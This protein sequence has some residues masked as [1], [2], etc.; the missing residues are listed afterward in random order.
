MPH[1]LLRAHEVME[2][3]FNVAGVE[4]PVSIRDQ[5]NRGH[6]LVQQAYDL[7]F[8][9]PTRERKYRRLLI[10]GAGAAGVSAALHAL[11][12]GVETV[13]VERTSAPFLLQ[14]LCA[15][16]WIDPAQY[17]WSA[18]WSAVDWSYGDF[19]YP[20]SP[21]MRLAWQANRSNRIAINWWQHWRAALA[22]PQLTFRPRDWVVGHP[23]PALRG[24]T[25]VGVEVSFQNGKPEQF[26]M[27]LWC[28][29]FGD[30]RRYAPP[31]YTGFAF[32]QTDTFERQ[33]WGIAKPPDDLCAIVS[34]GGDGALQDIIRLCTGRKSAKDVFQALEGVGW[35]LPQEIRQNLF[36]E[37]DQAQRALL[38]C[39]RRSLDEHRVLTRLHDAY[40][41]AV[42]HLA[43]VDPQ[44]DT[45]KVEVRRLLAWNPHP[46]VLVHPCCHF[47]RC[48]GLNR[49][50]VL[51]IA[52]VAALDK[53]GAGPTILRGVGVSRVVGTSALH[54]CGS[55]WVCHGVEHEVEIEHRPDCYASAGG[56]ARTETAHVVVIRHG[57]A[58]L[59][60]FANSPLAFARQI[61]PFWLPGP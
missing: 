16:R 52:K 17:D 24:N 35:R 9:G 58:Q 36:S 57:V 53:L 7:G 49:F 40:V 5:I 61:M 60:A 12:L 51:L 26:G 41:D 20:Q 25:T 44:H 46:V 43:T 32:W 2:Y 50:L 6:W 42:E 3:V 10:C 55:P 38:W 11:D 56:V 14:R 30:E 28:V 23:R 59:P 8:F 27:M 29:G 31:N 34:G 39:D 15:S 18:A 33:H 45:L 22:N 21:P 13:L 48:Y 19:P 54:V 1:Q 47:A 37:E 4:Y